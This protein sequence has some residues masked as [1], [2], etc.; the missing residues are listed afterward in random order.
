MSAPAIRVEQLHKRYGTV[1]ALDGLDLAVPAGSVMGLLGPNGSGKT[2]TVG[3]LSTSLRADSGRAWVGGFD[4]AREPAAVRA[5]SGFA[6]QFAAVDANLTG[7][8]NLVLIAR[9]SRVPR[10]QAPARAEQLLDQFG[11]TE[12]ADR[13]ARTYSGGMRR[14]LDV[15]A[16]LVHRPPVLFFDEPT[17][18]LDPESRQQLWATIRG[19]AD[20]GTSVLLTTQYLE[21]ADTL[22][23]QVVIIGRGRVLAHGSPTE[24]KSR[25]GSVVIKLGFPDREAAAAAAVELDRNGMASARTDRQ[26]RVTSDRGSAA[27]VDVARALDRDGVGPDAVQIDEP[28]LDD[29]FLALTGRVAESDGADTADPA[30]AADT[31]RM[32]GAA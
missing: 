24:L 25:F 14:R 7:R 11:L 26:V 28:T 27:V 17:T 30:D 2:T 6:G 32:R 21:E 5:I 16:A 20:E 22:A 23:D 10:A 15:A 12:A 19:L 1:V 31:A 4:V 8:E 18:G 29:V 9:L 13:L 3:V